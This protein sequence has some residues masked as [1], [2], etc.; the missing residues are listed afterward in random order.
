MSRVTD[1]VRRSRTFQSEAEEVGAGVNGQ[2]AS[3]SLSSPLLL[4]P[5]AQHLAER[6]GDFVEQGEEASHRLA[7]HHLLVEQEPVGS[8][9]LAVPAGE[10][11]RSQVQLSFMTKPTWGGTFRRPPNQKRKMLLF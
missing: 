10:G 3:A 11:I 4:H 1:A 6:L 5:G 8:P 9:F 7:H 2:A